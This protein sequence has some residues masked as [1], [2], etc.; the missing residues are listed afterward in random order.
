MLAIR[1]HQKSD[2]LKEKIQKKCNF[3]KKKLSNLTKTYA[4]F[5]SSATF[6]GSELAPSTPQKVSPTTNKK[7]TSPYLFRLRRAKK[8]RVFSAAAG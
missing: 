3:I 5:F 4:F 8:Y 7:S 1:F 2:I 6:G